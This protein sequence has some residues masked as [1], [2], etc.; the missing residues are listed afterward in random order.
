MAG[1][2]TALLAS[3]IGVFVVLRRMSMIGD[4]LSHAAL[5]G[6]AGVCSSAFI[7]FTVH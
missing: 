2:I 4:S 5:A 3:V 1:I 6:V 7:R